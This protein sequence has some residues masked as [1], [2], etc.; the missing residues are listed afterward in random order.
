M[1]LYMFAESPMNFTPGFGFD[2]LKLYAKHDAKMK[3]A[4]LTKEMDDGRLVLLAVAYFA[5]AEKFADSAIIN[6]VCVYVCVYLCV[7]VCVEKQ[8]QLGTLSSPN[9]PFALTKALVCLVES[10]LLLN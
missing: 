6:S 5:S 10:I 2:P 8:P 1:Y 9:S 4:L 3:R 7:C